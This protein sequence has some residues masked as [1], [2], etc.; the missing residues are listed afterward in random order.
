MKIEIN[1]L[2]LEVTRLNGDIKN[3]KQNSNIIIDDSSEIK[4]VQR[5]AIAT[6]DR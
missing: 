4:N 3:I 5:L 6:A 2:K 1:N